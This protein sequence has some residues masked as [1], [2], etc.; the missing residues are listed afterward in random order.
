MPFQEQ[1]TV[2]LVSQS[3]ERAKAGSLARSMSNIRLEAPWS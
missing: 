2:V 3:G 1:G